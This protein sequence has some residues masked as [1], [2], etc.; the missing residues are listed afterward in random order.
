VISVDNPARWARKNAL[1]AVEAK[2]T[3][4]YRAGGRSAPSWCACSAFYGRCWSRRSKGLSPLI[5]GPLASPA[6]GASR[7]RRNSAD[8]PGGGA[9][10]AAWSATAV[11]PARRHGRADAAAIATD[12][13][14]S[15]LPTR[16]EGCRTD[17]SRRRRRRQSMPESRISHGANRAS[18]ARFVCRIATGQWDRRARGQ[19]DLRAEGAPLFGEF[20]TESKTA[21]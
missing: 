16:C 12:V 14:G 2:G 19:R 3:F 8:K 5:T 21:L 10:W 17:H 1:P 15:W 11:N 4:I 9:L 18:A 7:L 13:R 20:A 6:P